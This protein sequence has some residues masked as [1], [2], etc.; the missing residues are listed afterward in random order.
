MRQFWSASLSRTLPRLANVHVLVRERDE[1]VVF[2][3]RIADGAA[4]RSYGIHVAQLAG[5]PR[6]VIARA[7]EV[8]AELERERTVEHL[9]PVAPAP[10]Q[11]AADARP[12]A[13]PATRR[14]KPAGEASQ[15]GLFGAGH[16][17]LD[18]LRALDPDSMTPLE[19][20]QQLSAWKAKWGRPR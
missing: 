7:R 9:E 20:L 18:A 12:H 8:L 16:P 4:D 14:S 5:L 11:T 10:A 6:A 13:G 2:L 15:L 19:A 3:H 17:L 1:Q